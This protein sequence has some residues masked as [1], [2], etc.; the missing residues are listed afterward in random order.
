M[1]LV[2]EGVVLWLVVLVEF[3][4]LIVGVK[5]NCSRADNT[6]KFIW[7]LIFDIFLAG[8]I[9]FET[10]EVK[11]L[12]GLEFTLYFITYILAWGVSG[13]IIFF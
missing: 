10:E 13:E 6:L 5:V 8:P 12:D 11:W 3:V 4:E 7:L 9:S 2:S 1:S